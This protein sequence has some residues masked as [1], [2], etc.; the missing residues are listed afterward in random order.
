MNF[1]QTHTTQTQQH[2]D[3]GDFK[4]SSIT[5]NQVINQPIGAPVTYSVPAASQ[6]HAGGLPSQPSGFDD[7][8]DDFQHVAS[9]EKGIDI[10]QN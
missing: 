6:V 9:T 4:A 2:D 3:F 7:D 8:F 1:S 5:S 10:S